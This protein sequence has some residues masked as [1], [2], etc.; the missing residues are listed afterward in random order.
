MV[1]ASE[2]DQLLANGWLEK[3]HF[4]TEEPLMIFKYSIVSLLFN[5][6]K[7]KHGTSRLMC[8]KYN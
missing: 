1:V 4:K 6:S 5:F 2:T 8:M 7:R 3:N